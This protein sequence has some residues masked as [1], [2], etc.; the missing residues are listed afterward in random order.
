MID[1]DINGDALCVIP[2]TP[3]IAGSRTGEG[4]MQIGPVF[5]VDPALHGH[6]EVTCDNG[7]KIAR[8]DG[9]ANFSGYAQT[10]F[11]FTDQQPGFHGVKAGFFIKDM[12]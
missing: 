2:E 11:R 1:T 12:L 8:V 5:T 10:V 7:R 4:V 9:I 6:V 3:S